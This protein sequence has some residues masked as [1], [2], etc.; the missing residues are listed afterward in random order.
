MEEFTAEFV[1]SLCT[2]NYNLA[3]YCSCAHCY[4]SC[5]II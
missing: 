4:F 1:K 3:F 5:T 2:V